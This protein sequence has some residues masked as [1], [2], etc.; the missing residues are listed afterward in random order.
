MGAE[1]GREGWGVAVA[2]A[3]D[4]LVWEGDVRG[5]LATSTMLRRRWRTDHGSTAHHLI[6]PR[7][8]LPA[9]SGIVQ[10]SVWAPFCWLA[11]VWAKAIVIDGASVAQR[12]AASGS[13]SLTVD[14]T[15]EVSRCG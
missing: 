1:A 9:R 10:A 15:G 11:E 7:S 12:A 14:E 6:D 2:G 13:A 3:N 5:G 8:G 4:A